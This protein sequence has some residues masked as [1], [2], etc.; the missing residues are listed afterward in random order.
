M[1]PHALADDECV[2][3]D[4]SIDAD[5]ARESFSS[6]SMAEEVLKEMGVGDSPRPL[7]RP[8]HVAIFD[9]ATEGDHFDGRMPPTVRELS[10]NQLSLLNSLF[11]NWYSYVRK[12]AM[13]WKHRKSEADRKTK[14]ELARLRKRYAKDEEGG[15]RSDRAA[16]VM[17]KNHPDY[18]ESDADY[19][20]AAAVSD[21]L[22]AQLSITSKDMQ[23][24][25][26]EVTIRQLEIEAH[27]KGRG[28][29]HRVAS[30]ALNQ[31]RDGLQDETSNSRP[32]PGLKAEAKKF[33][34]FSKRA[35]IRKK[36]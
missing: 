18:I 15:K 27:A 12:Q 23:V 22:D 16:D 35:D 20:T 32:G 19:H 21:M 3:S 5:K 17:A 33:Q 24:I 8:E 14:F 28:F 1:A 9:D 6:V 10:L 31:G 36:A 34:R 13:R 29:D 30:T 4:D 25:S 26:R 11:T 2:F 7:I